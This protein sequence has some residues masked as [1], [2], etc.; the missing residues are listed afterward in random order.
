MWDVFEGM[1]S[2]FSPSPFRAFIVGFVLGGLAAGAL[3]LW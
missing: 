1:K 2:F 3:L